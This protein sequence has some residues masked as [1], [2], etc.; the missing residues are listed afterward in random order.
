MEADPL[1]RREFITLIILLDGV[2][3]GWLLTT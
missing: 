2:V 3:N 1:N